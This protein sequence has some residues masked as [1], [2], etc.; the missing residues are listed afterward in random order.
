[1]TTNFAR[2]P[3][4]S[5]NDDPLYDIKKATVLIGD[6][7]NHEF[8][9]LGTGFVYVHTPIRFATN[10]SEPDE[11]GY[12]YYWAR[13]WI[14]T[15]RHVLREAQIPA[16][17]FNN[18]KGGTDIYPI[19]PRDW[20][21][22]PTED[23]I[24]AALPSTK[25]LGGL[26]SD[27]EVAYVASERDVGVID[28]QLTARRD[29]FRK[30]NFVEQT[31]VC[32]VGYPDVMIEGGRKDYPLIRAGQIAQVQGFIEGDP[33][34]STFL[35]EGSFDH[36]NSG[37]PVVVAKGTWSLDRGHVLSDSVVIGMVSRK[38]DAET[39]YETGET[40]I[41]TANLAQ[42]VS[43]DSV[44]ETI[45]NRLLAAG[46]W[47]MPDHLRQLQRSG[48]G[49]RIMP[50]RY[51]IAV[52]D[53]NRLKYVEWTHRDSGD[54][55]KRAWVEH[56]ETGGADDWAKAPEG[57]YLVIAS[58]VEGEPGASCDFPV[59]STSEDELV[60]REF[61]HA[62]SPVVTAAASPPSA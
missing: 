43:M 5:T 27:E 40:R 13:M 8:E 61:L 11:K 52:D 3:R 12:V 48:R 26:P 6:T 35:I 42:V 54:M 28:H 49:G 44:D 36:G 34:H 38:L 62:V 32:V 47:N 9:P 1:M 55:T 15:C 21:P 4:Q 53:S 51:F 45:E 2:D 60:L 14:V 24:V 31:T 56:R 46:K 18:R 25:K 29:Q 37:G 19:H 17:R 33:A 7:G 57:R 41:D 20:W 16:V 50:P 30:M 23:V 59:F 10:K 58:L 22:H 39:Q